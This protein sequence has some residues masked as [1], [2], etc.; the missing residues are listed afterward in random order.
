M[1]EGVF[2]WI[3]MKSLLEFLIITED[4]DDDNDTNMSPFPSVVC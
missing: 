2:I 4:S 1:T 3:N